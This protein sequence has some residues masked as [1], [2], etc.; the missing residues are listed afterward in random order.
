MIAACIKNAQGGL[1]VYSTQPLKHQVEDWATE[2]Y[3]AD[4]WHTLKRDGARVVPV[5]VTEIV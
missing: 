1:L 2:R 3:G 4:L 5:E